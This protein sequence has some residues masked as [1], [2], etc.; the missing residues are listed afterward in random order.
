MPAA[1]GRHLRALGRQRDSRLH[2][3][4]L[5]QLRLHQQRRRGG[6]VRRRRRVEH[7]S[8]EPDHHVD[9]KAHV[10]RR[11]ALLGVVAPVAGFTNP[12]I[13]AA[14]SAAGGLDGLAITE[15]SVSPSRAQNDQPFTVTAVLT[16]TGSTDLTNLRI[17]PV[18]TFRLSDRGHMPRLRLVSKSGDPLYLLVSLAPGQSR[19]S[20]LTFET[21]AVGVR[22][23][24]ILVNSLD[25]GAGRVTAVCRRP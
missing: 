22:R 9:H 17:Y 24:G 21:D 18:V 14:D 16:N 20:S 7:G 5:K 15:I 23:Y 10:V 8:N 12:A 2:R 1:A 6:Y 4:R 19:R 3:N 11:M 25:S 13:A